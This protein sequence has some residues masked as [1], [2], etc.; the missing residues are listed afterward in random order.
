MHAR[1]PEAMGSHLIYCYTLGRRAWLVLMAILHKILQE[2][3]RD[4]VR[5]IYKPFTYQME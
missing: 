5:K 2:K 4:N 3:F 1:V